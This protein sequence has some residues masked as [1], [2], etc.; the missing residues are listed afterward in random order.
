MPKIFDIE[1]AQHLFELVESR[2]QRYRDDDEKATEDVLSVLMMVNHLRE[3]IAPNY[4][5]ERG[6]WP[7]THSPAEQFSRR[8]YEH[9]DFAVIRG[10]CN[11]TKHAK[12]I[13]GT[14]TKYD[15]YLSRWPKISSVKSLI[16]GVPISHSVDGRPIED[17]I[18]PVMALYREWFNVP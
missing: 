14:A 15:P 9:A 6:I 12:T 13:K 11:G 4:N 16:R 10:L 17:H 1:H 18:E 2:F 5:P 8:V 3:W 7:S